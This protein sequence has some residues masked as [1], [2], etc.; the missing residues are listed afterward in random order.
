MPGSRGLA[1]LVALA[2]LLAPG[3]GCV[4]KWPALY[5]PVW[6]ADGTKL[7]YAVARP[8]GALAVR[9]VDVASRRGSEI[10]IARF[11]TPP[12]ALALSPQGDKV[13]C[14]F[15]VREQG[16]KSLVRLHVL[17]AGGTADKVVWEA[18][19]S[20]AVDLAW[21]P[22]GS[23][24]VVAADRPGGSGLYRIGL[25]GGAAQELAA[26]MA[27]ARCP[28]L[29]PDGRRL[30]FL[31]RERPD[32][33]W[34]LY[35]ASLDGGARRRIDAAVCRQLAP[36]YEP[37]WSPV[38]DA[39]AYVADRFLRPGFAE[40]RIWE[41][42][43][44]SRG[45][46][47]SPAS[48][49]TRPLARG[50]VGA[51]LAPAWSPRGD[52]IAFVSLPWALPPGGLGQGE[53]PADIL[54]VDTAGKSTLVLAA[55]GL[56]NLMPSWSPDGRFVAFN[57]LCGPGL[58]PHVVQL[59][60][61]E[62]GPPRPAEDTPEAHFLLA[63]ARNRRAPAGLVPGGLP[64]LAAR[65]K[66]PALAAWASEAMADLCAARGDWAGAAEHARKAAEGRQPAGRG[67]ALHIL[68][69][70]QMR[71]G[72]PKGALASLRKL[73]AQHP[74]EAASALQQQLEKGLETASALEAELRATP[75]P[76]L[77]LA[78]ANTHLAELGNPRKALELL[79]RLLQE[80]PEGSHLRPAA[81]AVFE[82]CEQL[83]PA[84]ASH[85]VA[86]WAARTLGEDALA[87]SQIAFLAATAA[88]NADAG[89]ALR[90]AERFASQP[91]AGSKPAGGS[92]A[93][94]AALAAVTAA[95][96][97]VV[98]NAPDAALAAYRQALALGPGPAAAQAALGAAKLLAQQGDHWAAT[99]LLLDVLALEAT[100][101]TRRE[102]LRLLA[103]GRIQRRDPLA[104]DIAQVGELAAGGFLDTALARGDELMSG[105]ALARNDPRR[106]ALRRHMAAAC[107]QLADCYLARG[108]AAPA[109]DAARRW[110]R[111][112]SP[113]DSL[114]QA[115][116]RLA[117]AHALAGDQKA[118]VE[119]LSRLALE[120]PTTPEG[121]A[122]RRELLLLDAHRPPR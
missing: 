91:P 53:E 38:G 64:A 104:Y 85:R 21:L 41:P 117:A 43:A 80:H 19:G 37:A 84:A 58:A 45:R 108:E 34:A 119:A 61:V 2:C 33:P 106:E 66:D 18:P 11:P 20:G 107:S 77:A 26:G 115:L 9:E 87:P 13:A 1:K 56:A 4:R 81:A 96:Q 40:I 74:D 99:G 60:P 101:A 46:D 103:A 105:L 112:A 78:L 15:V 70:A 36:G 94:Q 16:A 98:Q 32:A 28:A 100:A 55:D 7:F 27:E 118:R 95:E 86:E 116:A 47:A 92:H 31:A 73:L 120:F 57:T 82:A 83:G 111:W 52:A 109:L 17:A 76:V 49:E 42:A 122:A 114:A 93:G 29:S 39:L 3:A 30:A 71:L 72:D 90:W 88:R 67:R 97:L 35:L 102:A 79:F 12:A 23:G 63:L 22:D 24:L 8:D 54:V 68:A 110:M 65:I 6:S 75:S 44:P 25:A 48:G 10:S 89:A 14:A 113:G 59:A 50:R 121:A 62:G 69:K 51:C 5:P